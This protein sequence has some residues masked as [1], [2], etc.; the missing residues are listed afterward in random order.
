[1]KKRR[2]YLNK[3]QKLC[4][5]CRVLQSE[6]SLN[7]KLSVRRRHVKNV[8]RKSG[9]GFV[10]RF[11]VLLGPAKKNVSGSRYG[12]KR[13][14]ATN[15]VESSTTIDSRT[16]SQSDSFFG[17]QVNR[18]YFS[19]DKQTSTALPIAESG[20]RAKRGRS[21]PS[22]SWSSSD[23]GSDKWEIGEVR[24]ERISEML[25]LARFPRACESVSVFMS[26][27]YV[28][29]LDEPQVVRQKTKLP[30]T[31]WIP[32]QARTAFWKR[33]FP[34][35]GARGSASNKVGYK[36]PFPVRVSEAAVDKK[37]VNYLRLLEDKAS[38]TNGRKF[39]WFQINEDE[40]CQVEVEREDR[41]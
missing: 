24:K 20:K 28:R 8:V 23:E 33:P 18:S 13:T 29:K 32:P 5:F 30:Y 38:K 41:I 31:Q 2:R 39:W 27:R 6:K 9:T 15:P 19:A 10:S 12:L 40:V 22:G 3:A 37:L 36:P 11:D 25:R 1:M 34:K 16:A 17:F 14:K 7:I 21:S 35:P 4:L 26:L